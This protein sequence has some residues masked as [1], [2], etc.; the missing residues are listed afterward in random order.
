MVLL[1]ESAQIPITANPEGLE[2][3]EIIREIV[4]DRP[5]T[6]GYRRI[7]AM[8]KSMEI[9]CGPKTINRYMGPKLWL[10]SNRLKQKVER[11][12]REG[13][14]AVE[15]PNKRWASDITVI[16]AWNGEKGRFCVI[17]DCAGRQV[18]AYRWAKSIKGTT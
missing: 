2:I 8:I 16:K 14:V 1:P 12:R 10:S 7:H 6:Y 17:I 4:K 3:M 18:L 15:E 5:V 13:V 11:E 9:R